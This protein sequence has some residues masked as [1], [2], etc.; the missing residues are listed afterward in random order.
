MD[1]MRFSPRLSS[2]LVAT[3]LLGGI[4]AARG[5][6]DIAFEDFEGTTYGQW[7][8]TGEAFG[9]GPAA[10]TLQGQMNVSGFHGKRL[11]NSFF[12]GDSTTGTLTSPE[13]KVERAYISF[14]VGG[15][16]FEGRTCMNLLVEGKVARTITGP[17]THPGGS[18]ELSPASWE[19]RDLAGRT[20]RLQIVDNATGGWGH[21]NIDHIVFTD[22]KPPIVQRDASRELVL[23]GRYLQIPVKTGAKTRRLAL[24]VAGR[25]VREC[26]IELAEGEPDWWAPMDVSPWRG[27]MAVIRVDRLSSDST[28]LARVEQGDGIKASEPLYRERLRPQFHFSPRRGWNNDPNG[29]V[30]SHGE[31]H[32]FYQNNPYGWNWGNMHWAHAVSLDLVHWRELPIALYPRQYG[33]WVFSGSAVVD[34]QNTSGWHRGKDD[35]LVAAYTSTGRGECIVYSNDRGRTWTEFEGNPVVKHE[36]RDPRLLWFEPGQHWVMCLYDEHGGGRYI[37]FYTSQD[38]KRWEFQSRIEGFYECPDLF[39]LPV[40]GNPAQRRWVLTAA[41]S[42]YRVGRFDGKVFTPETPKLPGHRGESFYAAQTYSD[43]PDGRRIQVG[44]GQMATRGMPFNQMMCFPCELGLRGTV[45]G[46][47]LTW[48]P[49]AE[50][51]LLRKATKR[52]GRISLA[53]GARDPLA[54]LKAELI[55]INAEIIPGGAREAGFIL[56]GTRVFYDAGK[57]ELVVGQRRATVPAPEGKVAVQILCDRTSIEVFAD[58]GMIYM[59]SNV[60]EQGKNARYATFATGGDRG[61]IAGLEVHELKSIW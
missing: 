18:E 58:H 26:D 4:L 56:R 55:E 23:R 5:A 9:P 36:G 34:R 29:L 48:K 10:G 57:G 12:H 11:V 43:V 44:W 32:L 30:Y 38:L 45:D 17:N 59:P 60:A 37:A 24:V 53:A 42:E 13:F 51:S 39:E 47:R 8:V 31:Y 3:A 2:G 50:L 25:V 6:E 33:D 16:G 22:R 20:A 40:D 19:V 21:I 54:S 52:L 14:S 49:V 61:Q 15:G 7:V 41:S 27:S 28:A 46:P 1:L 35:L